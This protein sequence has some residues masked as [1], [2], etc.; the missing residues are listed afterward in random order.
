MIAWNLIKFGHVFLINVNFQ[1]RD[2]RISFRTG[3]IGT[4]RESIKQ[5][6]PNN[7][8]IKV[9]SLKSRV[10]M[11]GAVTIL[12]LRWNSNGGSRSRITA[13]GRAREMHPEINTIDTQGIRPE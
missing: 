1:I 8:E 7:P 4:S 12:T 13:D 10:C 11:S 6:N 5:P 3:C 2:G 9:Q